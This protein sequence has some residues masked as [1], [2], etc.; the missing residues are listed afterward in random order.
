MSKKIYN[1]D[2]M[3]CTHEAVTGNYLFSGRVL[4]MS[5][6]EDLIQLHRDLQSQWQAITAHYDRIGLSH[7]QNVIWDVS[8]TRMSEYPECDLS[9]FIFADVVNNGSRDQKWF[10]HIDQ[11]WFEV[12]EYVNSKN[13]FIQLAEKLN[14]AVPPTWCFN[15]KS[16]IS[17]WDSFSYPCYLKPAVS[18]DGV[19]IVRCKDIDQL[20]EAL[21]TFDAQTPLQI[22]QEVKATNFLN[23]QYLVTDEGVERFAATEQVLDGYA[24]MGNRYPTEHQPW[25]VVEPMAEWMYHQGM[26]G[27][28]AFDVAVVESETSVA[29]LA[30]E[31][32][33]RFNGASYPTGVARKLQLP[34]WTCENFETKYRSLEQIDLKELEFDARRGT[35]VIIVNWGTVLIGKLGILLAG[36]VQ[37]QDELR[38]MVK[39]ILN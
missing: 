1:H 38:A 8:H 11:S 20:K 35:G 9:V 2:I 14:V 22:R 17:D 13:N 34:S 39:Q 29:Y 3:I 28:F 26:K 36:T 4:G 5:E 32:N 30:I 25:G 7:S 37:Q 27:I 12:V 18:V 6:P 19:G 23:L 21:E 24:H 33:P 10:H 31:C 16:E 15:T